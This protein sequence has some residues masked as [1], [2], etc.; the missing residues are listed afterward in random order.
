MQA[1]AIKFSE[2]NKVDISPFD[3]RAPKAGEVLIQTEYSCLS[4]GTELRCLRGG[5]S[6]T[7]DFPFIPG[8]SLTGKII[9]TSNNVDFKL[10]TKVFASGTVDAG[11]LDL[12]W[13]GHVSHAV[14][15]AE[16]VVPIP[17]GV[18]MQDASITA[19]AAIA[20][21]GMRLS[22]PVAEEKIVIVGLGIIGQLS[23]RLHAMSGADIVACDLSEYR[24]KL[25]RE[26]G[27]N[28]V[29]IDK[30]LNNTL[31]SFLPDGADIVI[32]STGAAAVMGAAMDLIKDIPWDNSLT[33]G[34]RFVVQGS[35]DGE[36]KIP[37]HTVFN[38]EITVLFP[39]N[40]QQRDQ[41]AVLDLMK[42]K[43][44]KVA[45]LITEVHPPENAAECYKSLQSRNNTKLTYAFKW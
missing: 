44:L 10:A 45:N 26:A 21:H 8:Y 19:L 7:A 28:A 24:V 38:K 6:N 25:A 12:A 35:Y 29:V 42:Q 27:I 16:S 43:S 32:D 33:P 3:L 39:R 20:F 11:N 14:C 34:G 13:G 15:D 23:A 31:S 41:I 36:I 40:N 18:S 17:D 2:K 22:R 9:A 4:P 5:D 37:Y 1:K 30:D